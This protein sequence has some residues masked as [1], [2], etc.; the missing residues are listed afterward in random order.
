M[1]KPGKVLKIVKE[2]ITDE[3]PDHHQV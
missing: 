1:L 3:K 2:I